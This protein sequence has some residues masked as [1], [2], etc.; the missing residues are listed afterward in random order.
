M[1]TALAEIDRTVLEIEQA[2]LDLRLERAY[3]RLGRYAVFFAWLT[4]E[5]PVLYLHRA[6][7]GLVER[8]HA[9]STVPRRKQE[10]RGQ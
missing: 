7:D 5:Y 6:L 9:R 10:P 3:E 1:Q 8:F 4:K 2:L